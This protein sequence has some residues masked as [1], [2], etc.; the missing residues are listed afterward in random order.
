[1]FDILIVED[2]KNT[3]KYLNALISR[4]NYN[5][6]TAEDGLDALDKLSNH[7]VDVILVDIMM[8]KMDGLTF[9]KRLRD[10]GNN[11]PAIIITA[12]DSPADKKKGFLAG[13]DDYI[14]KPVDGEE[15]I[16]RIKAIMRRSSIK[17]DKKLIIGA[18]VIDYDSLTLTHNG[19]CELLPK[20]EF[21]ILYKLLA[22]PNKI[23]T[24]YQLM[25]EIWGMESD[26]DEQTVN[27]HINRLRTRLEGNADFNIITVRG[28]GYKAVRHDTQGEV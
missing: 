28:L 7:H 21:L 17:S 1:M 22:Y 14:T 23:F 13:S 12:K 8:P 16:L 18:T 5:A 25:D 24:R 19:V 4:E 20:K 3:R 15:L 11:T 2:D 10:S 6:I 26:T 27:V 9:I